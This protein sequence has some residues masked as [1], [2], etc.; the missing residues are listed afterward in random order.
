MSRADAPQ[1]LA[2]VREKNRFAAMGLAVAHLMARPAFAGASFGHIATL[3]A[4]QINRGDYAF[5][6]SGRKVVG[7]AGWAWV[8]EALGEAWLREER[9]VTAADV[10]QRPRRRRLRAAEHVAGGH[11]RG[12]SLHHARACARTS[13]RAPVIRPPALCRRARAPRPARHLG[14]DQPPPTGRGG[15]VRRPA[16][17]SGGGSLAARLTFN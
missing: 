16:A 11:A 15:V 12:L 5:V 7:F 9:T 2:F 8:G 14:P 6:L 13:R 17:A 3:L 10:A 1:D 4:G